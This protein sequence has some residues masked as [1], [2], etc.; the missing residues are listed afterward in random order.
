MQKATKFFTFFIAVLVFSSPFVTIAQL[1][2]GRVTEEGAAAQSAAEADANTDVNKPLYFGLGCLLTGLPFIT[3]AAVI[4]APA[5]ILGTYF[6]QPDPPMSRLIGKSP[7]YV[8]AHIISY[9]SKRGR[10]Q[11][12]W[13]SVGCVTG[14][15]IAGA[16]VSVALVSVT[17]ALEGP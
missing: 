14:G 9:K 17:T 10:T 2:S 11:A 13:T 4:G 6:Y 3:T 16:L 15:C 8:D 5:G 12:L 7:E 1:H